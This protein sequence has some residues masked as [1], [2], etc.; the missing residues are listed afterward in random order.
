MERERRN[1][2]DFGRPFNQLNAWPCLCAR[3]GVYLGILEI[4]GPIS[5]PWATI[6]INF[7]IFYVS[8][9]T[10]LTAH[11]LT[12]TLK[13]ASVSNS[14]EARTCNMNAILCNSVLVYTHPWAAKLRWW[15]PWKGLPIQY[16][17]PISFCSISKYNHCRERTIF[18]I[19]STH[20]A[21][22]FLTEEH[23]KG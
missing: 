9:C 7:C 5:V 22:E 19:H 15:V 10:I 6:H 20:A 8:P 21:I 16:P 4:N 12:P 1:C 14:F 13:R 11:F 2:T 3:R 18:T 17:T 23:D